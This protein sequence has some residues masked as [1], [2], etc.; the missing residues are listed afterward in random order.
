MK[1]WNTPSVEDVKIN[2]TANSTYPAQV[3]DGA[4]GDLFADNGGAGSVIP[5]T[6]S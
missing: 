3:E 4:Y 5:G 6:E 1:N 2:E